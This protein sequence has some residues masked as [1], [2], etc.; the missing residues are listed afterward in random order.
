MLAFSILWVALATAVVVL[1][2]VRKV[3]SRDEDG[4]L[5]VRDAESRI[6]HQQVSVAQRLDT[7]DQWGKMVTAAAVVYGLALLTGFCYIGWQNSLQILR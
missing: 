7:I 3:A 1:A 4:Y 5:H 6:T 2:T